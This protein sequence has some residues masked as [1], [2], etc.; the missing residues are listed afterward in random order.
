MYKRDL[1]YGLLVSP[2]SD[3]VLI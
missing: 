2:H 1:H 3:G